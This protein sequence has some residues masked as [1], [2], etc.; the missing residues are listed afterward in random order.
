MRRR[1]MKR[2]RKVGKGT[3]GRV[4]AGDM[5]GCVRKRARR[6]RDV[7]RERASERANER[8]RER[9]REIGGDSGSRH[10][11][12]TSAHLSIV[13]FSTKGACVRFYCA[14]VDVAKYRHTVVLLIKRTLRCFVAFRNV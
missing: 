11:H 12:R 6:T 9:E 5:C 7:K 3:R 1:K 2:G 13:D 10:A 4:R 8:E 14:C